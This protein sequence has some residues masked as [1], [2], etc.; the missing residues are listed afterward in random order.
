MADPEDGQEDDALLKEEFSDLMGLDVQEILRTGQ[1]AL[2]AN[3]V[4]KVRLGM[5]NHQ[6]LA[7]LRNILKD[8]GLVL[9]IPPEDSDGERLSLR[10]PL[11]LPSF[12]TPPW[13]KRN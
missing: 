11:D 4:G 3:L 7:I 1:K 5:A 6:E 9:G 8:N 10:P 13:E 12:E 2:F